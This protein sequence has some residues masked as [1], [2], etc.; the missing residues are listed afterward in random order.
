[1]NKETAKEYLPLVQALAE[2]KTIQ[3]YICGH[4]HDTE[5]PNFQDNP[6]C[7]FRIKPPA[8]TLRAWKP[9]E[10]PIGALIR[11]YVDVR[12]IQGYGPLK[13]LSNYISY[14][15]Y[16]DRYGNLIGATLEECLHEKQYS[17]DLGKTW[18]P[19]GVME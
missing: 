7:C 2:G 5:H 17:I 13:N 18:L 4:Y 15:Q 8:P 3:Q 1:M 14:V 12:V 16:L 11:G 19:C 9:K 6:A 10:V